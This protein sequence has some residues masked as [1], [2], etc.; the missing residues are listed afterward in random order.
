MSPGEAP[1]S[2]VGAALRRLRA[3]IEAVDAALVDLLAR[4]VR[5]AGETGRAKRAAGLPVL[6]PER[7]AA[8][9][10]RGVAQARERGLD[11]EAV[12]AVFW[13]VV[14]MCREAQ[15]GDA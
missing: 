3:E 15:E 4:R 10:R 7:E 9:V 14:G 13:R 2:E 8:V 11:P 5:V 6:D 12:R 1:S